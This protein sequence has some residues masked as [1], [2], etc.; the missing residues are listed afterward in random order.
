MTTCDRTTEL[1]PLFKCPFCGGDSMGSSTISRDGKKKSLSV[2]CCDCPARMEIPG[3]GVERSVLDSYWNQRAPI[4]SDSDLAGQIF[5]L[6]HTASSLRYA[7]ELIENSILEFRAATAVE[8]PKRR[9]RT[10][11][12]LDAQ[13]TT[14]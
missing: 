2:R 3:G 6:E 10:A 14:P 9:R 11:V 4:D 13:E 5:T 12:T 7:A 1:K 8:R